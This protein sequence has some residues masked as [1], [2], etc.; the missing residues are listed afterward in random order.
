MM[1]T[2]T[3]PPTGMVSGGWEFV[4]VAYGLSFGVFAVYGLRTWLAYRAE[5]LRNA[6]D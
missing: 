3:P 2:E 1:L 5:Q 6:D 4:W